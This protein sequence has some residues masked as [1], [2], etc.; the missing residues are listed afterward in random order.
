MSC[1]KKSNSRTALLINRKQQ[2]Y[3]NENLMKRFNT[4]DL[5]RLTN[6][7]SQHRFIQDFDILLTRKALKVWSSGLDL[8]RLNQKAFKMVTN[9]FGNTGSRGAK[10]EAV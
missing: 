3:T 9:I 10:M 4:N 6:T 1:I 5:I 2:N 7:W 8:N